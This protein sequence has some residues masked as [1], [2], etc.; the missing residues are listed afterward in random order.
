MQ[1]IHTFR[2]PGEI[3]PLAD[4][5]Q[6][7]SPARRAGRGGF[8]LTELLVVISII[9]VLAALGTVGVL[10][11]LDT[12]KQTRIKT[13]LDSLDLALRAYKEKYGSYPPC[14]LTNSGPAS[15]LRQHVARAFPRYNIANLAGDLALAVDTTVFRPDQALVFWLQGFN[16]DPAN[17][18]VTPAPNNY[19][20]TGGSAG[21]VTIK[22]APLF[23]FDKSRL[24]V[25]PTSPAPTASVASYFPAGVKADATGAPYL[26]W[27]A[28][29]S[30]INPA[31]TT[32]SSYGKIVTPTPTVTPNTFN[33]AGTLF[34]NAGTAMPYWADTINAGVVSPNENW[35]NIDSFQLIASGMDGKYGVAGATT[36]TR[37]YPTGAGYDTSTALADDDN[38]T[39]FCAKARLGD[40][41]P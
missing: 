23:D 36:T 18:F 26:Y 41:K 9:A 17:P 33:S 40:A 2:Q 8:T 10:R 30:V 11:A 5:A 25:V 20:I 6:N 16:P 29:S 27:E 3:Q 13:E 4:Q 19:A 14:D 39:N 32:T 34:T 24:F 28:G 37:L 22:L 1:P 31:S 12:A 15:A 38:V 21:S 35:V 7:D